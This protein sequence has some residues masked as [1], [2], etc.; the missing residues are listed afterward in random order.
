MFLVT[1]NWGL[2]SWPRYVTWVFMCVLV[3]QFGTCVAT[4]DLCNMDKLNN[5][6]LGQM[7]A[8]NYYFNDKNRREFTV[9]YNSLV[10]YG[11]F[12]ETLQL[13]KHNCALPAWKSL[14]HPRQCS[15]TPW[16][17]WRL[18]AWNKEDLSLKKHS[19]NTKVTRDQ[20]QSS[21]SHVH[22]CVYHTPLAIQ[23]NWSENQQTLQSKLALSK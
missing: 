4:V 18:C 1:L 23:L 22:V 8:P 9:Q 19:T 2:W 11:W 16:G 21:S 13:H 3:W 7:F 6:T 14:G 20:Y 10:I 15:N 5:L 12:A 17:T